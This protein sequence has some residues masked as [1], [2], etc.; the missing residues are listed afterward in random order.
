LTA[1]E[2]RLEEGRNEV[3]KGGMR[4]GGKEKFTT[5]LLVL[6]VSVFLPDLHAANYC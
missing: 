4:E 5:R 6:S 2:S 3:R 1:F